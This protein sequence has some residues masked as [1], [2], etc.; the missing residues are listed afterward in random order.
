MTVLCIVAG[1]PGQFQRAG[2]ITQTAASSAVNLGDNTARRTRSAPSLTLSTC[3]WWRSVR[4][5][6]EEEL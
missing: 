2:T 6:E 4:R 3:K 1:I 5:S